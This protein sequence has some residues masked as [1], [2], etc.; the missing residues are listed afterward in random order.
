M[1]IK[2]VRDE[3][4]PAAINQEREDCA[5]IAER[6]GASAAADEIRA[7]SAPVIT[8]IRPET[9]AKHPERVDAYTIVAGESYAGVG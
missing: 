4:L 1:R 5:K 8:V 2:R 6:H 7:R 9:A 3:I